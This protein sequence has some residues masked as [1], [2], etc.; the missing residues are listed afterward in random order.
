MDNM[1]HN[2]GQS[3]R[4]MIK[5]A[6]KRCIASS[7]VAYPAVLI[8]TRITIADQMTPEQT[9]IWIWTLG[10]NFGWLDAKSYAESFWDN[11]IWGN[12]LPVLSLRQLEKDLGIINRNHCLA[13]KREIEFCFSGAEKNHLGREEQRQRSVV[14]MDESMAPSISMCTGS[15]SVYDMQESVLSAEANLSDSKMSR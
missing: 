5:A 4:S 10:Y 2:L 13:I 9:S 15:D 6:E 1:N 12:M 8:Q 11:Q 14:F 7:F 3:F